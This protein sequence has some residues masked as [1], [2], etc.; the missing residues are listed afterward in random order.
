M[1]EYR[2]EITQFEFLTIL[3]LSINKEINNHACAVVSGLISDENATD[4]RDK[5]MQ[6]IWVQILAFD[7]S[8]QSKIILNGIVAGFTMD[9][10]STQKTLTLKIMSGTWLMDGRPHFRTFQNTSLTY[11]KIMETINQGY[12]DSDFIGNDAV[13][14]QV[15][16]L[17]LQYMETDW[18]F[19]RRISSHLGSY[20]TPSTAHTGAKYYVGRKTK[21]AF[22][23]SS[24]I[25]CAANKRVGEFMRNSSSGVGSFSEWDYLEYQFRTREIYDLW[26]QISLDNYTGYVCKIQSEYT[27]SELVHTYHLRS[28][29]GIEHMPV[30]NQSCVG[31]SFE[32]I[33]T[34]V[35]QDVVRV[36]V[37]CDENE[38]QQDTIWFPYSTV[39]STPDGPGW[40]CMPEVG[41]HVR[42]HIPDERESHAYVASAVHKGNSPDRQN[43]DHKSI[44]TFYGKELLMTP[45]LIKLTNNKGM[46]IEIDDGKG[47]RITSD[48]EILIQAASDVTISSEDESLMISGT[49][50]V[51]MTQAGA[52]INLDD[53]ISF[54]GAKFRIQ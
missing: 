12:T 22:R 8:G 1:R 41:D 54:T 9:C 48:K 5:L 18:A 15:A 27:R 34:E 44:K 33:I 6:D 36:D 2:I 7:E 43:P 3:S 13:N 49:G 45:D 40:Y 37:V 16:G 47:I 11:S 39:Y 42:L 35:K 31:C 46:S 21:Q 29:R 25:P 51:N 14:M 24:G 30:F 17:L 23:V 53:D 28:E 19:L 26:D 50:S 20:V 52:S 4:Y 32:A 38:A 10:I